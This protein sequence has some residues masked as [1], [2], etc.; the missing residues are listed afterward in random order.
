M[1][2]REKFKQHTL[3]SFARL[4]EVEGGLAHVNEEKLAGR[5]GYDSIF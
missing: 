2:H 5:L 1:F 3:G 4:K